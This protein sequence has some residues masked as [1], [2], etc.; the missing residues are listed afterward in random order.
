ML[1]TAASTTLNAIDPVRA[2]THRVGQLQGAQDTGAAR[3]VRGPIANAMYAK[4]ESASM[5]D[6]LAGDTSSSH[7]TTIQNMFVGPSLQRPITTRPDHASEQPPFRSTSPCQI[8]GLTGAQGLVALSADRAS[9]E[10]RRQR[11]C[12][13]HHTACRHSNGAGDSTIG[14]ILLAR[15]LF[16]SRMATAS[17]FLVISLR[18]PIWNDHSARMAIPIGET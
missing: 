11:R 14:F 8:N 3:A 18:E 7:S 17:S 6:Q 1:G 4:S 2:A 16:R 5:C 13:A 9:S 12:H 10:R 15:E